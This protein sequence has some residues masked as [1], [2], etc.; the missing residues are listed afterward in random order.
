M[1][2]SIGEIYTELTMTIDNVLGRPA[3]S[4]N[5]THKF[6]VGVWILF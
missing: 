4:T 2:S 1:H 6:D 3:L 5:Q